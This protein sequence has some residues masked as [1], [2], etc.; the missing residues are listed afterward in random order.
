[1]VPINVEDSELIPGPIPAG[2]N[3]EKATETIAATLNGV[4]AFEISFAVWIHEFTVLSQN[5]LFR[6]FSLSR[7]TEFQRLR[8]SETEF[9]LDEFH[10]LFV[11]DLG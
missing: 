11:R 7:R 6:C 1:M 5:E 8:Q 2:E 4:S 10:I 3:Q 9:A